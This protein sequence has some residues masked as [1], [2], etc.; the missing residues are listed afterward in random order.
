MDTITKS[1]FK[2][3]W[4]NKLK[5]LERLFESWK[6]RKL[7]IF[8]KTCIINSLAVS[9]LIYNI[10]ILPSPSSDVIKSI[11]KLIF[12]FIWNK[13]DRIKRK[14]LIGDIKDGGIGIVDIE[15]KIKAIKSSWIS[16][17]LN[18][19]NNLFYFLENFRLKNDDIF[20]ILHTNKIDIQNH[21]ILKKLPIFYRE[22][23]EAFSSSKTTKEV[24][25]VN[26]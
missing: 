5:E 23:F 17:I 2:K 3:K 13:K 11:N 18:G 6:K 1:V 19:E 4:G 21:F 14:T 7:T 24:N 10:S 9:R 12:N 25:A 26:S 15:S 16:Y 20:Y 8:G 22:I